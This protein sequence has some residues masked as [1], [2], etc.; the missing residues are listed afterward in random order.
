MF[1]KKTQRTVLSLLL[2]VVSAST[3]SGCLLRFLTGQVQSFE[4]LI[5]GSFTAGANLSYCEEEEGEVPGSTFVSCTYYISEGGTTSTADL[6]RDQGVFGVVIDPLILQLPTASGGVSGTWDDGDGQ[7]PRPLLVSAATSFLAAPGRTVTAEP[8]QI[9]WIIDLPD[10]ATANLPMGQPFSGPQFDFTLNLNTAPAASF[11]VKAMLTGRIEVAGETY[12]MPMLP[13][14][15][16]FAQ[17]PTISIPVPTNGSIFHLV[18]AALIQAG[19]VS[20]T[21]QVYD[22]RSG[23][24]GDR[25]DFLV[26][27]TKRSSRFLCRGGL[28]NEGASC[29]T[30]EDCGGT[31]DQTSF[32]TKNRLPATTV[33]A[34]DRFGAASFEVKKALGLGAPAAVNGA[35]ASTDATHLT[36]YKIKLPRGAPKFERREGLVVTNA[37]G[38]ISIDAIAPERLLVPAAMSLAAPVDPLAAPSVPP[39]ACYRAKV[40]RRT[41]GLPPGTRVLVADGLAPERVYDLKRPTRVCVGSDLEGMYPGAE[42][43]AE[44]LLCYRAR[45]ARRFCDAPPYVRCR[46]DQDCGASVACIRKQ[47]APDQVEPLHTTD[48][49]VRQV[50]K[51]VRADDL[52]LPSVISGP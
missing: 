47:E 50:A 41:P 26:H 11:D 39:F 7:G 14:T 2:A 24:D 4:E 1:D 22:F 37:L 35:G 3:L 15:T 13:C 36:S 34:V 19:Q 44:P 27:R 46:E 49:I 17:V 12:F 16:D 45:L 6:L 42:N 18:Q 28:S 48:S 32:C 38:E 40:S 9:F 25:G 51:S 8:G 5:D 33:S 20:C 23:G 52:C 43:D 31:T 30:E 29:T 21:G 10:S